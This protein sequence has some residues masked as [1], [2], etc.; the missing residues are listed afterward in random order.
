MLEQRE[1]LDVAVVVDRLLAVG[2]QVERV[3]HVDVVEVGR[4]GLVGHVHRVIQRQVPDGERLE[5]RV[6]G[7]HAADV[8]VVDLRQAGGQLAG[9]GPG[10]GDHDDVAGGFGV[11]V[12]AE[13]VL[14]DDALG[15]G[16]VSRDDVVQRHLH[17]QA[18]Q[19]GAERRC[20][21][22]A[23]LVLGEHHVL[24]EEAALAEDVDQ[25]QEVFLV[26]DAQVGADFV[27]LQIAGVDAHQDLHVVL[28][29]LEHGDLV[30][31]REPGQDAGGV[32]VVE[33]L[34]AHLQIEAAADGFAAPA[35]VLGLEVDVLV[36]IESHGMILH[37]H[38]S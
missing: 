25:P 7:G 34:A 31:R 15:V 6:T 10:G 26:G 36:A 37:G 18:L 33:Q 27:A 20:G 8:L 35:D 19:A 4:R 11:F 22:V 1:D 30:V 14:A 38:P 29:A 3:D 9:A 23:L 13:A 5:L 2:G 24:G 12:A 21:G 28:D 32:H 16:R 17:A